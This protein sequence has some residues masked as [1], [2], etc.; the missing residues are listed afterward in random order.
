[1]D[2]QAKEIEETIPDAQVERVGEGIVVEFSSAVLFG[3]DKSDLSVDAEAVLKN[4]G[5]GLSVGY[6]L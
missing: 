4:T 3:L 5:F 2:K 6:R 1:M